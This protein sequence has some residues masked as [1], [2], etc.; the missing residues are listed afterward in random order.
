MVKEWWEQCEK[1]ARAVTVIVGALVLVFGMLASIITGYG[2]IQF[3]AEAAEWRDQHVATQATKE[4]N[5]RIADLEQRNTDYDFQLL[6]G[7]LTK[8]Q[9]DFI[10][11]QIKKNE[12]TIECI[13]RDQC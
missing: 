7:G 8:S 1:K 3:D 9:I 4:K 12:K 6:S 5:T 11:K 2:L 13:R 10:N